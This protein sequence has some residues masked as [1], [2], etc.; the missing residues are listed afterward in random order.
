MKRNGSEILLE[1][2]IEQGTD[3][4]FGYPGGAI[5][6]IHDA[7]Y[8]YSDKIRHIVTSH[9]QGASHAADGYARV[10]GKPGVLLATSGPG[11]TN[12]VTGLATAFMDS[13][14]IVAITGNVPKNLIGR[15]SFQ[16]IDIAGIT[17]PITKCNYIVDSVEKLADTVREAFFV[18]MSGRPGPVLVDI[19]KDVTL[20][21]CEYVPAEKMGKRKTPELNEAEI[22]AAITAISSAKNPLIYAGGGVVYSDASAKLV[23]FAEQNDIPVITSMMGI[24]SIPNDHK[25]HFGMVGMH[26]TPVANYATTH[27]DLLIAIGTRFSDRVAGNREHFASAATV[28]H[29]DIDPSEHSKNIISHLCVVGDCGDVLQ[30]LIDGT[31]QTSHSEW[32]TQLTTYEAEKSI[33]S[34]LRTDTVNLR[35]ILR[36]IKKN[37]GEDAII[38]TDVGQ[39]QMVTAQAY[40]F[41][42]PKSFVSSCGLG[43]MGYGLG[44]AMGAKVAMP[45][46]E[47]IL[48]TGDGSFHMNMAEMACIASE[49]LDIKI[50][51]INNGVLGMVRQWQ[52]LF[53]GKRYS[54][55]E[56]ERKTDF[57]KLAE[58]F[59][60][61][62]ERI[63][64]LSEVEETIKKTFA[65]KGT[66]TLVE[67]VVDKEDGIYPIIPPGGSA[68]DIIL[69]N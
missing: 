47:V 24:S 19:P 32:T 15:D 43:T 31:K 9:E 56:V 60:L 21:E 2:L 27:C 14:P 28:L 39:H 6:N 64:E 51:V 50:M 57:V 55:V 8:H 34:M 62:G 63:L 42:V 7:L 4:I 20:A 52:K 1:V 53:Y 67:V 40:P 30:R 25:L 17:M 68:K 44:A 22:E 11:A 69:E 61:A 23:A 58:A 13:V 41:V 54:N 45:H 36:E 65:N 66:A 16:E 29:I 33:K 18:A 48:I 46:R 59:S 49:N 5:L 38:V 3:V 10:S 12:I 35:Y 26:G 37:V